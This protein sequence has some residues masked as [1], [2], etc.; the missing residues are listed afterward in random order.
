MCANQEKQIVLYYA[1]TRSHQKVRRRFLRENGFAGGHQRQKYTLTMLKRVR[2][3]I[4]AVGD[5]RSRA[6]KRIQEFGGH[7]QHLL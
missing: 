2:A 6:E 1:D 4:R 7:F 3:V 5:F